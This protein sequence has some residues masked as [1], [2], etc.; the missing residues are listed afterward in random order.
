M[1]RLITVSILNLYQIKKLY[2]GSNRVTP[3]CV[4]YISHIRRSENLFTIKKHISRYDFRFNFVLKSIYHEFRSV[5]LIIAMCLFF[6]CMISIGLKLGLQVAV[7]NKFF[8]EKQV[9][10]KYFFLLLSLKLA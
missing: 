2:T 8:D 3:H 5:K 1:T 6:E 7:L 10:K 9:L 4:A